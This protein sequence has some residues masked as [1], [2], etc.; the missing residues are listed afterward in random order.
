LIVPNLAVMYG[1]LGNNQYRLGRLADAERTLLKA[2]DI[3][4]RYDGQDGRQ[5]LDPRWLVWSRVCLGMMWKDIAKTKQ[6]T[7]ILQKAEAKLRAVPEPDV[8][9]LSDHAATDSALA[10]LAGPGA[11]RE[12]YDRRAAELFR[13]A[14]SAAEPRDLAGLATDPEYAR[15]RVRPDLQALLWDRMFPANPFAP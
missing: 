13:R 11:R 9:V 8:R 4:R 12:E 14:I 10:E 3:G 2:E 7:D 1:D 6:A 5:R 15:L